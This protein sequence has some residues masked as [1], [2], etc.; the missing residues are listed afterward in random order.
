MTHS[1]D[2]RT[3]QDGQ[4]GS[5]RGTGGYKIPS[6]NRFLIGFLFWFHAIQVLFSQNYNIQGISAAGFLFFIF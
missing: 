4:T 5:S 3:G 2:N 1:T 6:G